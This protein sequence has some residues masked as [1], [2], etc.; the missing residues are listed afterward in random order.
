MYIVQSMDRRMTTYP[1]KGEALIAAK[2]LAVI[3]AYESYTDG[4]AICKLEEC[5]VAVPPEPEVTVRTVSDKVTLEDLF[6]C[7]SQEKLL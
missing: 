5:L 3:S 1:T 2:E 6:P 4:I 7:A